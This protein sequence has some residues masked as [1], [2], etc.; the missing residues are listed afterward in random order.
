MALVFTGGL[1][2]PADI[3]KAAGLGTDAVALVNFAIQ[4]IGHWSLRACHL[5]NCRVGI[6]TQKEQLRACL[7]IEKSEMGSA[8]FLE[9]LWN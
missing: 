6:A 7:Q 2:R 8:R 1:R 5:N 9:V 4:A 3:A